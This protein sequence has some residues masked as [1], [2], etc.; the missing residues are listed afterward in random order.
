MLKPT[1]GAASIGVLRVDTVEQ[2]LD[3]HARVKEE[4]SRSRIDASGVLVQLRPGQ[5]PP[6]GSRA[7][8]TA[9]ML[10]EYIDGTE[11]DCDGA[12]GGKQGAGGLRGIDFLQQD[13]GDAPP[14]GLGRVAVLHACRASGVLEGYPQQ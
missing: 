5:A 2:L 6:E 3:G 12:C 7:V 9:I 10:E 14:T 1:G 8:E 11:I 13:R 4:L